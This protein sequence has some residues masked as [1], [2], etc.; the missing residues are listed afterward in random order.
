MKQIKI[1]LVTTVINFICPKYSA[2]TVDTVDTNDFIQTKVIKSCHNRYLMYKV[3]NGKSSVNALVEM[4][5]TASNGNVIFKRSTKLSNMELID[6]VTVDSKSMLTKQ[7]VLFNSKRD[8]LQFYNATSDRVLKHTKNYDGTFTKEKELE[9][10]TFCALIINELFK[11][12]NIEPNTSYVFRNFNPYMGTMKTDYQQ[13]TVVGKEQLEVV[14]KNKLEAWKLELIQGKFI[15]R[16][17]LETT[18]NELIK[19]VSIYPNEM[20]FWESRVY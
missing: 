19:Q 13:L 9:Q 10:N 7:V 18:T 8:S 12:I 11:K 16:I 6:S 20:E 14:G 2:Q 3:F 15:Y 17:W 5:I 4:N 1:I